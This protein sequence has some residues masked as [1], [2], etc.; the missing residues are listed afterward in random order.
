MHRAGLETMLMNYYRNIDR[1][2]LQFDFLVHRAEKYEYDDDI[3]QMGGRIYHV[4]P[5]SIKNFFAYYNALVCFFKTHPEYKIIHCH[6]DA[7]SGISLYIAKKFGVVI[8]IAHSH[9]NGFDKDKKFVLRYIAKHL[10]PKNATHFWG[11]STDALEFMF[12]KSIA[13]KSISWILPNAIDLEKFSF[14]ESIRQN[15]R[16]QLKLEKKFVIGHIG[17]FSYQKNHL[18]LIQIFNAFHKKYPESVLLL[19]GTGPDYIKIQSLVSKL[20]LSS[21]VLFLGVRE[22]ISDLLQAMDTFILPSHFEGFGIVLLEAQ[23]N[24][25]PCLASD[26][27]SSEANISGEIK[28]LSTCD[29]PEKWADCILEN[30]VKRYNKQDQ[31]RRA[32]YDIKSASSKLMQSYLDLLEQT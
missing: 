7:L 5:I 26:N 1:D 19:I 11:C 2:R 14:N 8:R 17:R 12:G 4:P 23:A 29:S 25:L 18:L 6:L 28:F 21:A 16:N 15:I 27:I 20:G 9:N 3:L 22:D 13:E 24:G 31:L 10:I 32:G 30:S